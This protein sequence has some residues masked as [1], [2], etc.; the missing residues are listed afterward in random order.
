MQ[1]S[2]GENGDLRPWHKA[3]TDE[4]STRPMHKRL[5]H[6]HA[7][8]TKMTREPKRR[9]CF[10]LYFLDFRSCS[11]AFERLCGYQ[12]VSR[13]K[14]K[15][16]RTKSQRHLPVRKTRRWFPSC[17]QSVSR[18]TAFDKNDFVYSRFLAVKTSIILEYLSLAPKIA[19][20]ALHYCSAFTF[21][22]SWKSRKPLDIG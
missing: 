6:A 18:S 7:K 11:F 12:I 19:E 8:S 15:M 9:R 16:Q 5:A 1:H 17:C 14:K 3:R 13:E 4:L 2:I 21:C 20:I 22:K 10:F